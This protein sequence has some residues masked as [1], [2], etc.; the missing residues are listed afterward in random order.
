MT[1]EKQL[2]EDKPGIVKE[3]FDLVVKTY[4]A[5]SSSF[6][7]QQKDPFA[8]PV[9]H[10]TLNGLASL[11]EELLDGMNHDVLES[12]LDPI[13][14][15]RAV[16]GFAPSQATG[17]ILS[18]KRIIRRKTENDRGDSQLLEELLQFESRIDALHLIAFDIYVRCREKIYQIKANEGKGNTLE[19]LQRAGLLTDYGQ[20]LVVDRALR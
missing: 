13:I 9:G 12:F 10:V 18:L 6:L 5:N 8:N 15:I 1:L 11:F 2:G 16:Q 14:R 3:W 19:A 7:K 20:A 17:F 4:P